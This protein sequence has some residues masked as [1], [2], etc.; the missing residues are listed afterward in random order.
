MGEWSFGVAALGPL[1]LKLAASA[2]PYNVTPEIREPR[3]P[4]L[5]DK[6]LA[7]EQVQVCFA[8]ASG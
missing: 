2:V 5:D 6:L 4:L 1:M 8:P 3:E 7:A